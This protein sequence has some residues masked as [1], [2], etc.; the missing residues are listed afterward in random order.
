M[1]GVQYVINLQR[2]LEM[3]YQAYLDGY[4]KLTPAE[5]DQVNLHALPRP[6]GAASVIPIPLVRKVSA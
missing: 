4:A 6:P 5:R 1:G 3:G 2:G